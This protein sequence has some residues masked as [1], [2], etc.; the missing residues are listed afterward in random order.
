VTHS[1]YKSLLVAFAITVCGA[2]GC[3]IAPESET[4]QESSS[5]LTIER[6]EQQPQVAPRAA[7]TI[8]APQQNAVTVTPANAPHLLAG[9]KPN[10]WDDNATNTNTGT[11]TGS[12]SK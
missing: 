2:A 8:A 5:D 9:P 6:G 4:A 3:A 11:G 10:P 12:N 1:S 7:A